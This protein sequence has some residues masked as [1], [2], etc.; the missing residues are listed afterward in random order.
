[1]KDFPIDPYEPTNAG[2]RGGFENNA[3]TTVTWE[4]L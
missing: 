1:M 4:D 2:L 3:D